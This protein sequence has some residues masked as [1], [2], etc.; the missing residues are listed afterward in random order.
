MT[1]RPFRHSAV[2]VAVCCMILTGCSFSSFVD[3][4]SIGDVVWAN[5]GYIYYTKDWF[6]G[7][8]EQ[9]WRQSPAGKDAAVVDLQTPYEVQH[10]A[11]CSEIRPSYFAWPSGAMGVLYSCSPNSYYYKLDGSTFSLRLV[12]GP[13]TGAMVWQD[14][15]TTGYVRQGSTCFGF[16]LLIE[17]KERLFPE[18]IHINGGVDYQTQL[19]PDQ[20]CSKTGVG[21]IAAADEAGRYWVFKFVPNAPRST[22]F[23]SSSKPD[24]L[25]IWWQGDTAPKLMTQVIPKVTQLAVDSQRGILAVRS[26]DFGPQYIEL[27]DVV[28]GRTLERIPNA[29]SFSFSPDGARIAFVKSGREIS[30]RNVP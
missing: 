27:I 30:V 11:I 5:D 13:V 4:P 15:G 8:H 12:A 6:D 17:R 3:P 16:S 23:I 18:P 9:L 26:S 7:P 24:Q 2:F 29:D 19:G 1:A 25:Y 28:S 21:T 14:D 10:D 20:D 22:G